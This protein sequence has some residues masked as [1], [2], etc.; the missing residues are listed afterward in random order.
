MPILAGN[1]FDFISYTLQ[2]KIDLIKELLD[3]QNNLA[4]S[5]ANVTE[6]IEL[7]MHLMLMIMI[8][9]SS[10]A[11]YFAPFIPSGRMEEDDFCDLFAAKL[12]EYLEIQ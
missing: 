7:N 1:Y 8:K 6:N 12:N 2:Q 9:N 4:A 10:F 5:L 11:E 3:R